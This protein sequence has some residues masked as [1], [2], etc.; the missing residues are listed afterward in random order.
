M[1]PA[2]PQMPPNDVDMA[3]SATAVSSAATMATL[4]SKTLQSIGKSLQQLE[5]AF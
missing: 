1:M 3:A 5:V 4:D 2:D